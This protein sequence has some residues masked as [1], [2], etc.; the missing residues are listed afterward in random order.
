VA[1]N[2]NG[3]TYFGGYFYDE[4]EAARAYD[5]TLIPLAGEFARLNFQRT[6]TATPPAIPRLD[7]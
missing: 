3:K 5:A 7:T 4:V 2:W 6:Q 1:F